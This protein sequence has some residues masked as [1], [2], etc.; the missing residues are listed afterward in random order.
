MKCLLRIP[1]SSFRTALLLSGVCL[2]TASPAQAAV[3][4]KKDDSSKT[5]A[6]TINGRDFSTYTFADTQ[7]KPYMWPVRGGDGTIITR[8]IITDRSQGDHPHHKGVWVAV[9]EVGGVKFWAEEGKIANRDVEVTV[10]KGNPAKMKVTNDWLDPEGKPVVRETTVISIWE[11]GLLGYDIVFTASGEEP[12]E[13]GDTK[14]GLFG[15]RMAESMKEK[16]GGRVVNAEGAEGTL[17]CWGKPTGWIDYSGE[18]DGKTFGVA[19]FD[20]PLNFRPSRYHVRNYGLFSISPFGESAYT[21]K[22]RPAEPYFLLPGKELRLRYALFVH[23]GDTAAA[24]TGK[25]YLDYLASGM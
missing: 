9:D 22:K 17:E 16:E 11:N 7:P 25:V 21:N 24:N 18:V 1:R 10:A 14:E 2:L 20:H 4:L 15:F 23:D 13:F 19:L 8:P 5:V 12:V 6:V 3:E